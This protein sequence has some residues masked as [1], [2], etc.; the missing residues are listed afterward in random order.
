MELRDYQ[1]ADVGA[2]MNEL[3]ADGARVMY[4]LPTGGGKTTVAG[5]VVA[6][7]LDANAGAR[8]VWL[9]HRIELVRQSGDRLIGAHGVDPMRLRVLS[10]LKAVNRL[11]GVGG[12]LAPQARDLLVCDEAHHTPAGSWSRVLEAWQGPALGL[13]A[14]PWR[15]SLKEGF[16]HLWTVLHCG[17]TVKELTAQGYLAPSRV[18]TTPD[19]MR[20][21][22]G[23]GFAGGGDF[24]R[25]AT[26]ADEENRVALLGGGLRW[27]ERYDWSRI[28]VYALSVAHATEFSELALESGYKVGLILGKQPQESAADYDRARARAMESFRSGDVDMLVNCEV[29]T[30]GVD[31]PDADAALVLRPTRS[32]ALWLQ[33]CG[34][35][36][37]PAAGKAHGLI[38]DATDNHRRLDLPDADRQWSLEPRERLKKPGDPILKTCRGTPDGE[39]PG[40]ETL[41]YAGR[42][43]CEACEAP[44]GKGCDQ[45]GRFRS[46]RDWTRA[47]DKCD[48]CLRGE[49]AEAEEASV[50]AAGGRRLRDMLES[51]YTSRNGNQ[52]AIS[53][54]FR[55]WRDVNSGRCGAFLLRSRDRQMPAQVARY[56]LG[57]MTPKKF[58]AGVKKLT[59][60]EGYELGGN[61]GARL[62]VTGTLTGIETAHGAIDRAIRRR[63]AE[64]AVKYR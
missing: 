61:D 7:Y 39:Y 45:C 13:T 19:S 60:L 9:T 18:V 62:I 64:V 20:H 48:Q 40:C 4:Q 57:T 32:L 55:W 43:D 5:E 25:N 34:R 46:W 28:L 10:P 33:M 27:A 14:T 44:F 41:N 37:R 47:K 22:L 49:E 29:L 63:A 8:C 58:V 3:A 54:G 56:G 17:P 15:M 36:L 42:H 31:I 59:L 52:I 53:A 6:E 23:K 30:E 38:L 2:L 24:S 1:R 26:W 12:V 35:V 16:D 51:G 11:K 21:V 50:K